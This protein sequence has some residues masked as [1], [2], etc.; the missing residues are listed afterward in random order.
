MNVLVVPPGN[1]WLAPNALG[2]VDHAC[3]TTFSDRL[4]YT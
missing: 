1:A 4:V 3:L 2:L